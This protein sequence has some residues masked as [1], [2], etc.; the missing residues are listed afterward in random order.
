MGQH[1]FHPLPNRCQQH[2]FHHKFTLCSTDVSSTIFIMHEDY[3]R[4]TFYH[5]FSPKNH[6]TSSPQ[7]FVSAGFFIQSID[8]VSRQGFPCSLPPFL[9][10][11]QL[12]L[13]DQLW[14]GNC[15]NNS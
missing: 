1:H 11:F 15:L 6:I 14:S 5:W 3:S 13:M 9:E 2:H 7:G 10:S 4:P 12:A 8:L